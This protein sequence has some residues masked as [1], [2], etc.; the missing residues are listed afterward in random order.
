VT[1]SSTITFAVVVVALLACKGKGEDKDLPEAPPLPT[2]EAEA[3][4]QGTT[5]S[6]PEGADNSPSDVAEGESG[7]AGAGDKST[8]D[9]STGD[10]STGDKSTGDKPDKE[11]EPDA[12]TDGKDAGTAS[13][14]SVDASVG[15]LQKRAEACINGCSAQFEKCKA[16]DIS[17]LPECIQKQASCTAACK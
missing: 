3:A 5:A 2:G 10:K 12:K 8:G 7:D 1:R 15:D 14:P 16:V 6:T 9:K 11:T 17:K 13:P 4:P